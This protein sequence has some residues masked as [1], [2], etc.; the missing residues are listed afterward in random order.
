MAALSAMLGLALAGCGDGRAA[1]D[2]VDAEIVDRQGAAVGTARFEQA[3]RGVIITV[4]VSGLTPGK[5]GMHL[6]EVGTCQDVAEGFKASGSHI[7]PSGKPHGFRN[8]RGP[9][10]GDL[11]NLIAGEEGI[12]R[13]ELYSELIS[14]KQGPTA[15]LDDDGS[16]LVIHANPDDHKS[17]PIG[18]AGERIACAAIKA[19][20]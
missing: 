9:H 2:A 11:P 3:T 5:H 20:E 14:L 17:Q 7:A 13:V 8:D 12:A 6:H 10:A 1:A 18:G 15:L 19:A 16:A 4:E